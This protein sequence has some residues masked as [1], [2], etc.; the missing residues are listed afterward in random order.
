MGEGV[1]F[2]ASKHKHPFLTSE[3]KFLPNVKKSDDFIGR[4]GLKSEV[5]PYPAQI[6]LKKG[7]HFFQ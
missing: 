3:G 7:A 6:P 5:L 1:F 4:Y 2:S